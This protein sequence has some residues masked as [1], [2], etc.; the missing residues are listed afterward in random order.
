MEPADQVLADDEIVAAVHEALARRHPKS[1]SR[2]RHGTPAEVVLRL[3][4]LKHVRSCTV[5]LPKSVNCQRATIQTPQGFDAKH[6]GEL[7]SSRQGMKR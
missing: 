7:F 2:G 4:I 5:A 6:R 3:L 1:R